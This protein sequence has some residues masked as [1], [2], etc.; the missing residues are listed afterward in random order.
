MTNTETDDDNSPCPHGEMTL[1]QC[2]I[3]RENPPIKRKT[4][5]FSSGGSHYHWNRNCPALESGQLQVDERGGIRG[6][7][8]CAYENDI[9]FD[10]DPCLVCVKSY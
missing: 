9:K 3:C 5:H 6:E 10:R 2:S 1:A 7:V 8:K 4:V